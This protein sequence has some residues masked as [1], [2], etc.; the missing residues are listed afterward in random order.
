MVADEAAELAAYRALAA[1]GR[2]DGVFVCDLRAD[3]VRIPVLAELPIEAV[4]LNRPDV[5]SPFPA[6]CE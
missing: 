4:T 2:V 6:V 1:Q 3:D 5:A